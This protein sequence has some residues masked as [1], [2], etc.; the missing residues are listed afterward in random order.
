MKKNKVT[1]MCVY[2]HHSLVHVCYYLDQMPLDIYI[3]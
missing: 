3:F 2:I 1:N